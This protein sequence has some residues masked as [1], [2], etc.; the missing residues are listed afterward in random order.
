MIK[1]RFHPHASGK[2]KRQIFTSTFWFAFL[3]LFEILSGLSGKATSRSKLI[4]Q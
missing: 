2:G 1:L 3:C 4:I